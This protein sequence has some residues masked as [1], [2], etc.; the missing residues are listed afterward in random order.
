[1]KPSTSIP[2]LRRSFG[3]CDLPKA[4]RI[5]RSDRVRTEA[6][7]SNMDSLGVFRRQKMS[8]SLSSLSKSEG[9]MEAKWRKSTSRILDRQV[10]AVGS[11]DSLMWQLAQ[12]TLLWW[13]EQPNKEGVDKSFQILDRLV[14]EAAADPGTN[15]TLDNYLLHA[16]L[17]NWKTCFKHF[18]VDLLPSSL[19]KRLDHYTSISNCLRPNIVAFTYVDTGK[20][21][22]HNSNMLLILFVFA[23]RIILD[24][25]AN[26][27]IPSERLVFTEN[28]LERLIEDSKTN[29]EL[30]P[31]LVTFG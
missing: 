17:K 11:F 24:G 9:T 2:R 16:A 22:T 8:S 30:R 25:A 4:W 26:C 23:R 28:L 14:E 6:C 31:T 15:F 12:T 13:A 10:L 7:R 1:M 18:Q 20:G 5:Y 19:V 3:K 21:I 27:P 29:P